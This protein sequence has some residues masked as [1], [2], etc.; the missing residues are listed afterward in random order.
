MT[1]MDGAAML[2]SRLLRGVVVAPG[3]AL[4]P[5]A[6][7]DYHAPVGA[8][9]DYSG[10]AMK[11]TPDVHGAQMINSETLDEAIRHNVA[12]ALAE[13]LGDGDISAQ[14]IPKSSGSVA[15]IVAREAATICGQ[16]WA[17]EVFR[18]LDGDVRI[19]WRVDE[20]DEVKASQCLVEISG[21][22]RSLL[23]GERTALN[24]L[25]TLSGVATA[26]RHYASLVASTDVK[27]LDTRKTLP[28][29]RIAQKYAV[30]IGGCYN[31]RLGLF[32]AFLIKENHINACGSIDAAV[33]A[34]KALAPGKPVE[35]EVETLEELDQALAAEADIIMLDNFALQD[36]RVAVERADG[37]AKLEASGGI[38]EATLLPIAE[39][40]VDYISIGLL[41]K[42]CRA[43]DL[44]MRFD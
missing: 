19:D 24:F 22:S 36:L 12:A 15:R 21:A 25:Q 23:T 5:D 26:S 42:D 10:P 27:I 38:S 34:A 35:V 14:L 31:H 43:I 16:P 3:P 6:A 30:G 32:D 11:P 41:T 29:L 33:T 1:L 9:S 37:K 20:G 39:T 28:G 17:N 13:D 7:A 2:L 18:R 8:F 44:S 40:G 4:S